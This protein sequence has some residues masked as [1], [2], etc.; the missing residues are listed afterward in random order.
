MSRRLTKTFLFEIILR[1]KK[2]LMQLQLK[3]KPNKLYMDLWIKMAL[4][5]IVLHRPCLKKSF[6]IE[7]TKKN[8][9]LIFFFEEYFKGI[10]F[11]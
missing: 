11:I 6:N 2:M 3:Q 10:N 9:L 4:I 7:F 1:T 8:Q 5:E